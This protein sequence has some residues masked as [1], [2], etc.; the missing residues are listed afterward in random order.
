MEGGFGKNGGG[1]R[2]RKGKTGTRSVAIK[3]K[4]WG[5]GGR[6]NE[7]GTDSPNQEIEGQK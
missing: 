1:N 6:E 3:K 5:G 2:G 7:R 4:K